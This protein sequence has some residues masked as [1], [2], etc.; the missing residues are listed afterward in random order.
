MFGDC[1]KR[2]K[3]IPDGSIDLVVTS[4]PYDDL[5]DYNKSSEWNFEIF[6][7]IANEMKRVLKQNGVIVWIVNDS[8]IKGSE[9]GS[10]FRQA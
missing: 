1:L 6:K 5:R 2:M 8:T 7:A 4:P 9:S 10:S 3:E